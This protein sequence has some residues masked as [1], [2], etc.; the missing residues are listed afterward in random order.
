MI[1]LA[2][3]AATSVLA[4]VEAI[5]GFGASRGEAGFAGPP[6]PLGPGGHPFQLA[7]RAVAGATGVVVDAAAL[8]LTPETVGAGQ[9]VGTVAGA[10]DGTALR[11]NIPGGA[12]AVRS[13]TLT[14]LKVQPPLSGDLV[15]VHDVA[16]LRSLGLRVAV[17]VVDGPGVGAPAVCVDPVP[18]RGAVPA[19]LTGGVLADRVLWLPDLRAAGL[20]VTVV[21]GSSPE[22][23]QA[24]RFTV[25]GVVARV[26]PAPEEVRVSGADGS[27]LWG[28]PGLLGAVAVV[29]LRAALERALTAA[30]E[31][32][33]GPTTTFSVTAGAAGV[34]RTAGVVA[35][36]SVVRRF[37]DQVTVEV[38]G[39]AAPVVP[40]APPLDA[41][42]PRSVTA[43]VVVRHHGLRLHQVSDAVPASRGGLGGPVVGPEPVVRS[44]PPAA[45]VGERV[46]RVGLVGRPVGPTDLSVQLVGTG[47]DQTRRPPGVVTLEPGSP[48]PG[49]P[50][51]SPQVVWV[52][53][54]GEGVAVTGAVGVSVTATRGRFLWAGGN[55]PLTLVAVAHPDPSGVV[56]MV[57]GAP[58]A[59]AGP[60]TSVAGLTLPAATFAAAASPLVVTDQF[61]TVS[62]SELTLRY[63]P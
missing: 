8:R 57:A 32:G 6:V 59:L 20:Q 58:F 25:S 21:S 41:R 12:R 33:S 11:V 27:P 56:V 15:E 63:D 62:L 23:F 34:V 5:A 29:D 31:G 36:G 17:A 60:E 52:T 3:D 54:P 48:G 47:V 28:A 18:A 1:P 14:D 4:G 61:C 53:L 43:D 40:P 7:W 16:G 26:A 37:G 9:S 19:Q 22:E 13:L 24:Q 45:L 51:L 46:R 42:A 10:H 55:V 38:E 44:L 35:T 49:S 50:G 39:R 30:V 2:V